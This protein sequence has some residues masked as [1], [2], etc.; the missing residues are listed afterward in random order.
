MVDFIQWRVAVSEMDGPAYLS[1]PT[2]EGGALGDRREWLK[3]I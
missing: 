3:R 1:K 2:E